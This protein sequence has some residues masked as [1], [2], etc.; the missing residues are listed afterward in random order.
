MKYGIAMKI[1]ESSTLCKQLPCSNSPTI[2]HS[3]SSILHS[4]TCVKRE[5][6]EVYTSRMKERERERERREGYTCRVKERERER[7]KDIQAD[8]GKGKGERDIQAAKVSE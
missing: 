1:S 2:P 3:F 4:S 6:R 8:R 7:R 5:R